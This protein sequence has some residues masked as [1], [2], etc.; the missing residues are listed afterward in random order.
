MK[1]LIF[2]LQWGDEC[3]GRVAA[4]LGKN[5]NWFVKFNSGPN[6]GHIVY[7]NGIKYPLHHLGAGAVM[8]KKIAL[9][10]G[11]VIDIDVLESEIL[12]LPIRPPL[13][14]SS[15]AHII[16]KS[17]KELDG[18]GS[19]VGSTKRGV[20]YCYADKMLRKGQRVADIKDKFTGNLEANIY[21]GLVPFEKDEDVIFES[22]QGV[23]LDID[24]CYC[25]PYATSSSV[26]P[27][28]YYKI[29]KKIGVCKPYTTKVGIH[30]T[31][32]ESLGWLSVLGGEVGTTTGRQRTSYWNSINELKWAAELTQVDEIVLTKCDVIKENIK[33][34]D[35]KENL[36]TFKNM[37]NYIDFF[38]SIFP[39]T[40]YLSYSPQGELVRI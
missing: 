29:D 3:K 27:N 26:M 20:S 38:V 39:Q 18:N 22:N 28:G 1:T 6:S 16:Q 24:Y 11:M 25:Y 17:H 14:V 5:A 2:G 8:S 32:R 31:N 40:K 23:M 37:N 10:A 35:E 13:Y 33:I 4:E 34:V 30:P 15:R 9:D 36:I 21:D 19:G 7:S 12:S